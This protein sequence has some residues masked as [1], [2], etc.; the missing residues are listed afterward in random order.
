MIT[1][2]FE[3]VEL[4]NALNEILALSDMANKYFQDNEPWRLVKEDKKNAAKKLKLLTNIIKDIAILVQPFLPQT[5]NRIFEFLNMQPLT[6][7][8][9]GKWDTLDGQVISKPKILIPRLEDKQIEELRLK[10]NRKKG[11]QE[12]LDLAKINLK[13]GKIIDVKKHPEADRLYI[14]QVDL[15]GGETR[16]IVSGLV[17]YY[18]EEELLG[19]NVILVANLKPAK[20][21]GVESM[22]MLLAAEDNKVGLEVISVEAKLGTSLNLQA[23]SEIPEVPQISIDDFFDINLNVT[24]GKFCL[25][26]LP[27]LANGKEILLQKV[28]QGKVS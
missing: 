21:K 27:L 16:Q 12:K 1:K 25:G 2:C 14:E 6:W 4:K 8:D 11:E 7:Q 26:E 23:D 22:G 9:L 15:G 10:F 24:D 17:K 20:L 13:V 18:T 5:S 19:K 3:K 28:K